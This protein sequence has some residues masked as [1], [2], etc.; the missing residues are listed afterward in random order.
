MESM[1]S[2]LNSK[3]QSVQ[4]EFKSIL[5]E[6]EMCRKHKLV[7][8]NLFTEGIINKED[9]MEL[10]QTLDAEVESLLIKQA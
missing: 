4:K 9:L 5:K 8:V 1:L 6:I 7:H 10:K 3:K 2:K